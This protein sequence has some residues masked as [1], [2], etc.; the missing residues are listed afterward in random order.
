MTWRLPYRNFLFSPF[1]RTL[2]CYDRCLPHWCR[3]GM[4]LVPPFWGFAWHTR[5]MHMI[6]QPC[7]FPCLKL[8]L[9]ASILEASFCFK[10]TGE[11]KT[12]RHSIIPTHAHCLI[13]EHLWV[14]APY[15]VAKQWFALQQ[16]VMKHC[17]KSWATSL[18]PGGNKTKQINQP[19]LHVRSSVLLFK[20]QMVRTMRKPRGKKVFFFK[21]SLVL[22]FSL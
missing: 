21:L 19:F 13:P 22:L 7:C 15:L 11:G 17:R 16:F 4:N 5:K 10:R 14:N 8:L 3:G 2:L 20:T 12:K 9:W 6:A 18:Q 1:P